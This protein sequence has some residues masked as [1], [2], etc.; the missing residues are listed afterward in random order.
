MTW[1][2][3]VPGASATPLPAVNPDGAGKAALGNLKSNRQCEVKNLKK[4]YIDAF[5]NEFPFLLWLVIRT[6]S[7]PTGVSSWR[8]KIIRD[9]FYFRKEA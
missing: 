1:P 7:F 4:K 6:R 3:P 9:S 5:V 8:F 2:P